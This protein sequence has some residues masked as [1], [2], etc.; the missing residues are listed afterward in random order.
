MKLYFG[1]LGHYTIVL[2]NNMVPLNVGYIAAYL[3]ANLG[4]DVDITLFKN[5]NLLLKAIDK[6]PPD[7]LAL[8]NYVWNQSISE[9]IFQSYKKQIQNGL[10]IWG[11][12]NF[13]IN[14]PQKTRIYLKERPYV[15]FYVP[16]EGEVPTFTIV[17][18]W[19][20]SGMSIDEMKKSQPECF[21][22]AYFLLHSGELASWN[23]GVRVQ[24]LNEIPSPY[25]AGLMDPF[26]KDGIFP[27]IEFSRGC[28]YT[29]AFCHTGLS[30]YSKIRFFNSARIKQEIHHIL[31]LTP[32]VTHSHLEIADTNLGMYQQDLE[33]M[34][35]LREIYEKTGFPNSM[36]RSTGK[37]RMD[38]VMQTVRAH[39]K[40]MLS[41]SVQ[42]M[43]ERVLKEIHRVNPPLEK[44]K[45]SQT[46]IEMDGKLSNPEIILGLPRDSRETHINTI[47]TLI[48]E[49]NPNIILQYT[50]M[51][52]PGTSLYTDEARKKYQYMVR[53]R[54]I[55]SAFGNY[56]GKKCF[57]IEEV[58]V[59]S[60][61]LKY[62]EYLEMRELFFLVFN[63]YSN[64]IYRP[65]IR[66]LMYLGLD[67][68][69]F[70]FH[71]MTRRK[72]YPKTEV[73]NEILD[74][75]LRE[76]QEEL[77][78][79][80]EE[81]IEFYSRK[82]NFQDLLSGDKGRNLTHIYK[83]VALISSKQIAQFVLK[84]FKE[85][86][87]LNIDSSGPVMAVAEAICRYILAHA[88]CQTR[89]FGNRSTIP[90][91]DSPVTVALDYD[92]ADIFS[93]VIHKDTLPFPEKKDCRYSVFIK[94]DA[95][96]FIRSVPESTPMVRLATIILRSDKNF[97]LPGIRVD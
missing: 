67:V 97:T 27:I 94:P 96:K 93:R 74:N 8:S 52:L 69:D 79:S 87:K 35:F 45:Q 26:L 95:A 83:V 64:G 49:V 88:E 4:K 55:P 6:S 89:M 50:L 71:I 36:G 61:D 15:D 86:I 48:K 7:V 28:P 1:D 73:L 63:I 85:Y 3:K 42:S 2:T 29:C 58:S 34:N 66:Y 77:F 19:M 54:V 5:P 81:L 23:I 78:T 18:S 31:A 14:E 17:K 30:Y 37:G 80:R 70:F 9:L 47:R 68:V 57:E 59:A 76:T 65:L 22:G 43:D 40:L 44:L 32:D 60:R 51:L 75:F 20:E 91:V 13:P 46:E 25:L 16:Y 12:P 72:E 11:G 41:M 84:L 53:Y 90:E 33:I 82:E 39:P 21:E 92:V 10:T 62:S 38:H 56:K 24:D